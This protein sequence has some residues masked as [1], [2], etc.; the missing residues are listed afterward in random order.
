MIHEPF[1]RPPIL[2]ILNNEPRD[3]VL[4]YIYLSLSSLDELVW[5]D[6]LILTFI[7]CFAPTE[8]RSRSSFY[9]GFTPVYD[10]APL[11]GFQ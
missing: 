1:L 6:N 5:I 4:G 9:H 3:V 2:A 10:M 11:Q 8:L 7:F